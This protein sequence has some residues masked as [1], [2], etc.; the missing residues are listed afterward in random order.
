MHQRMDGPNG[1]L[2]EATGFLRVD[3]LGEDDAVVEILERSFL[4]RTT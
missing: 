2:D 4:L 3:L 1:K